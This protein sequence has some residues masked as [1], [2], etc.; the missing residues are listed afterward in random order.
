MT[1]TDDNPR[2]EPPAVRDVV[3]MG[4]AVLLVPTGV[5]LTPHVL[6]QHTPGPQNVVH[7]AFGDVEVLAVQRTA[8]HRTDRAPGPATVGANLSATAA[9]DEWAQIGVELALAGRAADHIV[10]T[11]EF[12]LVADGHPALAPVTGTLIGTHLHRH[13]RVDG[14]L[15]FRVP[16]RSRAL[17]LE[18]RDGTLVRRLPLGPVSTSAGTSP[19]L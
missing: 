6:S 17:V 13:A 8:D 15:S 2:T 4:L 9:G 18:V 10:A 16:R 11:G 1:S 5:L 3:M 7:A 19:A 12:T 14:S